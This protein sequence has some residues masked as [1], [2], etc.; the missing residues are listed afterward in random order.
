VLR[1]IN[2]HTV[3]DGS[4]LPTFMELKNDGSTACGCWIYCGVF[5]SPGENRAKQRDAKGYLGHG[6]GFAW[7]NDCRILY[8]RA[9]ARPDGKP[10]SERKKLVWW[11]EEKEEWTGLD[12]PDFPT[13]T[14]PDA[15]ADLERKRGVGALGGARPFILHS[16]GL[17]WLF[18]PTG[19]KD[20]PLP[21]HY[22]PLESLFRN[23][24]YA[25]TTDPAGLKKERPENPYAES[26]GDPR[27]PYIL[28]THRLTEHH[29][30]GGMTR[31]LP[32]LAELQPEL[33]AEVSPELADDAGLEHGE[34]A[35]ISTP[36]G[37]IEARVLVTRR[38]H[39]V[40]IEG[41]RYIR[42]GCPTT[43]DIAGW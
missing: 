38:M 14:P 29:T 25:Q 9:S 19:L 16:D 20:G 5:P 41:R 28:T 33:F 1:E 3:A 42:S 27:F 21:A 8:N 13:T 26:P 39:S 17:G 6:W 12:T 7:P 10:W 22:E 34:W 30:A 24:L 32:H 4:L 36:R 31:T 40:W 2:G 15:K 18:V 11:D 23:P 37:V 43:G 35:I